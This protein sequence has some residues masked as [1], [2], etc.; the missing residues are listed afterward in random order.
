MKLLRYLI[1][2][3]RVLVMFPAE[4]LKINLFKIYEEAEKE[5][6]KFIDVL[7]NLFVVYT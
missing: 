2:F 7:V 4:T 3:F 1:Y 6:R 5:D